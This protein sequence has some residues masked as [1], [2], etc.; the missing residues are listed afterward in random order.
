MGHIGVLGALVGGQIHPGQ[1]AIQEHG[2][3]VTL[4][5]HPILVLVRPLLVLVVLDVGQVYALYP[6]T[7]V[8]LRHVGVP[9]Q[10]EGNREP[11]TA[12]R[13]QILQVCLVV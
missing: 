13:A 7:E 9:A 10:M 5:P 2:E 12:F 4:Q 8:V 3:S 1:Q 11:P 6:V